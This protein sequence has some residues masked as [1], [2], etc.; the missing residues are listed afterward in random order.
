MLLEA[1]AYEETGDAR[2]AKRFAHE[3]RDWVAREPFLHPRNPDIGGLNWMDGTTFVRGYMNTSNIGRR[4]EITW[5]P[6]FEG[7]YLA[8]T[9]PMPAGERILD[10]RRSD[11]DFDATDT[12]IDLKYAFSDG[13]L[14]YMTFAT[15][16]KSG[17]F[18]QRFV[19]PT[20]DRAPSSYR[21]TTASTAGRWGR[22]R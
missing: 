6:A 4:C 14:G 11:L 5:W 16:Y 1:K 7:F 13:V 8:P 9:G 12:T 15:G 21:R 20:P 3:V 19:G 17:G 18:D 22:S 2:Y 10:Y